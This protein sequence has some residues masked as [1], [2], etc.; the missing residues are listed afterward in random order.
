MTGQQE[1]RGVTS[2]GETAR[3]HTRCRSA[4]IVA[5]AR[6]MALAGTA[7]EKG[8]SCWSGHCEQR[9]GLRT[10]SLSA[11]VQST[12]LF[13][14][15]HTKCARVPATNGSRILLSRSTVENRLTPDRTDHRQGPVSASRR[16]TTGRTLGLECEPSGWLITLLRSSARLASCP[17]LLELAPEPAFSLAFCPAS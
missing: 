15:C 8:T 1:A 17:S 11:R 16:G 3:R 5:E 9:I 12:H 14:R 6:C 2:D 7:E 13:L 10:A 4:A